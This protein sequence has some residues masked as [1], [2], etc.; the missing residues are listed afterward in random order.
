MLI[1]VDQGMLRAFAACSPQIAIVV[2][3]SPTNQMEHL[4]GYVDR[5]VDALKDY[6]SRRNLVPSM[7][8]RTV[9]S[10]GGLS[11][12]ALGDFFGAEF[13]DGGE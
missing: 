3:S 11:F 9:L 6:Q 4:L 12:L 1:T 13:C 5:I 2:I 10:A 8:R 7:S